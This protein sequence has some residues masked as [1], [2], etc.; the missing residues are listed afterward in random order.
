MCYLSR[1]EGTY[2][3]LVCVHQ[4]RPLSLGG[5]GLNNAL[6]LSLAMSECYLSMHNSLKATHSRSSTMAGVYQ[7]RFK[8]L[9]T[10]VHVCPRSKVYQKAGPYV[11]I[12][13]LDRVTVMPPPPSPPP[14][15][16]KRRK[17]GSLLFWPSVVS[18]S[19]KQLQ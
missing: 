4:L 6:S 12:L 17:K 2:L 16:K 13:L 19:I 10:P 9:E 5:M 18:D 1:R 7:T 8:S 11:Y 15:K 14:L 3:Q